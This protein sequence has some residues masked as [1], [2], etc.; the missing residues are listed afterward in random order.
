MLRPNIKDVLY[1]LEVNSFKDGL[2]QTNDHAGGHGGGPSGTTCI[3]FWGG[4]SGEF[5][6]EGGAASQR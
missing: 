2:L 6:G 3:I 4:S 1:T 5:F